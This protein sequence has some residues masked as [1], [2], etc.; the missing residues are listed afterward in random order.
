MYS[1]MGRPGMAGFQPGM[2]GMP[3]VQYV[4]ATNNLGDMDQFTATS[5]QPW[6]SRLPPREIPSGWNGWRALTRSHVTPNPA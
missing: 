3:S 1:R 4:T 6:P 5:K 2:G